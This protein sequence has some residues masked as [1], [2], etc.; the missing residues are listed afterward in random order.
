[1]VWFRADDTLAFNAA[2]VRAGNAA[3]GLW[4]R[5]GTWCAQQLTDGHVPA[6]IAATLGS[7]A[8]IKR[9]VETGLWH[10]TETGFLFHEWNASNPTRAEV[11][12][13]RQSEAK[14]KSAFRQRR[15]GQEGL[16]TGESP[17]VS[18]GE[19]PGVSTGDSPVSRP[20]P[21]RPDPVKAP[22]EPSPPALRS[23][24]PQRQK[25]TRIPD[26]YTPSDDLRAW[27]RQR[28]FTGPQ[29][30]EVTAQFIRYWQAKAGKDATKV[31]WDKT[32]QNWL[33]REDPA[34]VQVPLTFPANGQR[35]WTSDDLTRILGPDTW[36]PP[37]PPPG[38]RGDDL[39]DWI[40]QQKAAHRRDR[41][42][43]AIA[44]QTGATA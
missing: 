10:E 18:T 37:K 9:L 25:A 2:V 13:R 40:D 27:A 1:V 30:D 29:L 38:L 16:S 36:Q 24:A 43:H 34:R 20:D 42:A 3:M 39:A 31:S 28:G 7:P 41:I 35:S 12:N 32:W 44:R 6:H 14:K 21:T 22:T 19:S 4:L 11:E 33:C 17:G 15:A 23:G 5:A 26:G 8:Q